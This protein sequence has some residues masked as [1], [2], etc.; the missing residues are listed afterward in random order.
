MKVSTDIQLDRKEIE[1]IIIT[2][3][4]ELARLNA[5][6]KTV[7]S[8]HITLQYEDKSGDLTNATVS[9]TRTKS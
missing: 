2:K 9:F 1:D 4:R 7:G 5:D 8:A 6:D 3:A